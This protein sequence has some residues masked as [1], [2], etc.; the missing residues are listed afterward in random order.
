MMSQHVMK[1]E[2]TS[3]PIALHLH[4]GNHGMKSYLFAEITFSHDDK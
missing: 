4:E 2:S 3:Q 1:Q